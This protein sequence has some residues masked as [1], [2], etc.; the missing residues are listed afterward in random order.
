MSETKK[1]AS[2]DEIIKGKGTK[3]DTIDAYDLTIRLG[4]LSSADLLEWMGENEDSEK[5]KVAGL[6]ILVKALVDAEGNRIPEEEREKYV[7][8]FRHK[9]NADNNRVI[10]KVLEMHGL[11]KPVPGEPTDLQGAI[12]ND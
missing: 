10:H 5:Q 3:Y 6:R 4:S 2:F 12:K 9:D 8:L 1:V 7:E 11:R